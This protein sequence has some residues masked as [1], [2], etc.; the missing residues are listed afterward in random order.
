M[1]L[2]TIIIGL[3][4]V[5]KLLG[6]VYIIIGKI[7]KKESYAASRGG[8][9]IKQSG[10]HGDGLFAIKNYKKGDIILDDIFPNAP[11]DVD[12]SKI[13]KKKFIKYISLEGAKVNHC[14]SKFN[15][16]VILK[17]KKHGLVALKKI[18]KGD[19]I[20]ADYN[21]VNKN[22]PFIGGADADFSD[23]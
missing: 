14:G 16:D 23:C 18:N 12:M 7:K 20:T 1:K 3:L 10:I 4:V 15:S 11:S 21:R 8:V 17:D 13:T 6:L 22:F 19:E 9:E 5:L 2:G